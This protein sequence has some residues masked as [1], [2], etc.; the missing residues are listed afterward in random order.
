M[1]AR[2]VAR[3][4]WAEPGA[5]PKDRAII[6]TLGRYMSIDSGPIAVNAPSMSTRP[7]D[8]LAGTCAAGAASD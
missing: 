3:V 7:T 1:P 8:T 4:I 6:G 5:P 2:K